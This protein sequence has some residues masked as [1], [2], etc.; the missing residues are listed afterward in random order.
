ME[1]KETFHDLEFPKTFSRFLVKTKI[2]LGIM[3][4]N[5]KILKDIAGF[6]ARLR[7][8][9]LIFHEKLSEI[10]LNLLNPYR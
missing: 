3:N 5:G 8:W 2:F 1:H 9:A 7:T 6:L 4:K 10:L